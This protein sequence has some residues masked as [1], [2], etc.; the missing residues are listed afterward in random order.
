MTVT[1]E[2]L[3]QAPPLGDFDTSDHPLYAETLARHG[4]GE[5]LEEVREVGR[6]AGSL[7]CRRLGDLAEAHPPVLHTH[8]RS[9]H[10]VDQVEYDA[11][12]HRL[13]ELAVGFGLAGAPW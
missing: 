3:N 8:D 10:R 2:V 4:A 12:Y 7:D 11:A 9:G 1:H 5:A 6:A 13:M